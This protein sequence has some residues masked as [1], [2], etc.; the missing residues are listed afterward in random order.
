MFYFFLYVLFLRLR[1]NLR[2]VPF[3][4]LHPL[5]R[6]HFG[7]DLLLQREFLLLSL[8][9]LCIEVIIIILYINVNIIIF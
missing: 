9:C 4:Y 2:V 8:Y 7:F 6:L 1:Q 5:M 3:V